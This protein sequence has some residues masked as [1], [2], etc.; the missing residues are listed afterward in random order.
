MG[1][2]QE[3][4][5]TARRKG[6]IVQTL[7]DE[8]LVYDRDRCKA[9]CLN[10]TASLIWTR[11]DGTQTTAEIAE[12][13]SRELKKQVSEEMVLV[14]VA[15]LSRRHLLRDRFPVTGVTRREALRKLGAGAAIAIPV[16]TSIVAP[17][18]AQAA[19]CLPSGSSCSNS[20]ECCSGLC[21]NNVCV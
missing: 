10:R 16:I 20:A 5:P 18:A 2:A 19:T 17:R 11:C 14:A 21:N 13:L 12:Q 8:T 7:P 15:K 3:L 9:H 4:R 1:I 6:L